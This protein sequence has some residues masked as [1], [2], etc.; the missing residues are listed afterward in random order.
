MTSDSPIDASLLDTQHV[1]EITGLSRNT[2]S[3]FVAAGFVS[4]VRQSGDALGFS[5]QDLVLLRTAQALRE[6]HLPTRRILRALAKLRHDLPDTMSLTGLHICAVGDV[7]AVREGDAAREVESGQWLLR[8]DSAAGGDAPRPPA[9]RPPNPAG[10][11][12]TE[13]LDWFDRAMAHEHSDVAQAESA[14]RRAIALDPCFED[15]YV[16]LG[17]MLCEVHRCDE[18]IALCLQGAQYCPDAPL[19]HFNLAVALEDQGQSEEALRAYTAALRCDPSLD[20]A[21]FN[22][23]ALLERGGDSRGALPPAALSSR[24][25]Y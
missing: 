10:A 14:Y 2:I 1:G 13:A 21:H 15:A 19:I 18:A 24:S 25:S 17:A 8:L 12:N 23:A 20:D 4:P 6:A 11:D 3:S 16:N 5:F 9:Q 7:V 22:I